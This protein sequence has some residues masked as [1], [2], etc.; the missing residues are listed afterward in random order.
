MSSR[1]LQSLNYAV[2]F[3]LVLYCSRIL[4]C[5]AQDTQSVC[6]PSSCGKIGS[7]S[8]PFRL[9]TD[10]RHCGKPGFELDCQ[11][12][13]TL[14]TFKSKSF[15]VESISYNNY[16]IRMTDP[17]LVQESNLC[18][19][20]NYSLLYDDLP[21]D[22]GTSKPGKVVND[23]IS[24]NNDVVFA[25]CQNA[26]NSPNYTLLNETS[27]N[28]NSSGGYRYLTVRD[29][30]MLISD[31]GYSCRADKVARFSLMGPPIAPGNASWAGIRR[32][33][34]YGFELSWHNVLCDVC[35]PGISSC[36]IADNKV[37]C[38][39]YCYE[40]TPYEEK[41]FGCK[42]EFLAPAIIVF[43]GGGIVGVLVL[44]FLIGLCCMAI[45]IPR[46]RKRHRLWE[47]K[48]KDDL[49]YNS[50]VNAENFS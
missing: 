9:K 42:L 4:S 15:H 34:A 33:L 41:S 35:E 25:I 23:F 32:S 18:S 44:R 31:L 17:G 8:Y 2:C 13:Q 7:I 38:K 19:Y 28:R 10:P 29:D 39:K 48:H 27:C 6:V 12:N 24:L 16:T 11:N 5:R 36:L 50:A 26:V 47:M 20:P 22:F 43:G 49:I 3:L 14:I 40:D 21:Y 45:L 1:N 37:S 46:E 30:T